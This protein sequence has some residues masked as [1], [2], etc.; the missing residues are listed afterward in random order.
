MTEQTLDEAKQGTH[1]GLHDPVPLERPQRL[2]IAK[3]KGMSADALRAETDKIE[4]AERTKQTT[5]KV[6]AD[7]GDGN[8]SSALQ[9]IRAGSADFSE[10]TRNLEA[11]PQSQVKGLLEV[12]VRPF[13][14]I[15]VWMPEDKDPNVLLRNGILGRGGALFFLSTAGTG[16]STHCAQFFY[17]CAG[18]VRF[19]DITPSKEMRIW[20]V[21]SEDSPRRMAQDRADALAELQEQHPEVDWNAARKR[22]KYV[23]IKGKVGAK[24]LNSLRELLGIAKRAGELPDMIFINP[25]TAFLGGPIVDGAYVTPFLRGGEINRTETIGLQAILE[26]YRV[27]VVIYHHTPKPPSAKEIKSWLTSPFPEYQGAGSADITNWGR[28]F[29]NMMK[30]PEHP[31]MRFITAGKN[32]G[33]LDWREVCGAKRYYIAFS[34]KDGIDGKGRHAW[35]DVTD[36]ER[37]ELDAELEKLSQTRTRSDAPKVEKEVN[38]APYVV[39]ALDEVR[40][41]TFEIVEEFKGLSRGA[42]IEKVQSLIEADGKT[43]PGR[44]MLIDLLAKLPEDFVSEVSRDAG[45][46]VKRDNVTMLKMLD[47]IPANLICRL[48]LG[49]SG[50]FYGMRDEVARRLKPKPRQ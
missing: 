28:T 45:G 4:D 6:A 42:L 20:Y 2:K 38:V 13:D 21:Q 36:E 24:F 37:V 40:E 27:G 32:G 14:E 46:G 9:E 47:E 35:R 31:R 34:D 17:S 10:F 1:G 19:C 22:V 50:I 26:E 23:D 44:P 41:A 48:N 11:V 16:K 15:G 33:E 3:P 7:I 49:T 8:L 12:E 5:K 43:P 25:F 30:F 29:L 39:R 18:G